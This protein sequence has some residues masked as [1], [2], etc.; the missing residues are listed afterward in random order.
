MLQR[1]IIILTDHLAR[2]E[3]ES[4]DYQTAWYKWV[5]ERL[6]EV[7]L[8]VCTT[9]VSWCIDNQSVLTFKMTFG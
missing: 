5:I 2:C 1:F 7:F 8:M 3:S 4:V 6:Q 9:A